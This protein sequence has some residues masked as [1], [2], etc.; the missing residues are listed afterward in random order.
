MRANVSRI[1]RAA[2]TG[3]GLPFGPSG[4]ISDIGQ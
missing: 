3:S 2:A 1:S 4:F